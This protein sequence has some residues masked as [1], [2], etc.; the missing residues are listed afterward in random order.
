MSPVQPIAALAITGI[1]IFWSM[2]RGAKNPHADVDALVE[3]K[4]EELKSN[5]EAA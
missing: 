5:K 3:R 1:L 2:W 4:V